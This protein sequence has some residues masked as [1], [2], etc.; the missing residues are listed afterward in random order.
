MVLHT[1]ASEDFTRL[2]NRKSIITDNNNSL[3]YQK[4]LGLGVMAHICNPSE[5]GGRDW[6]NCSSRPA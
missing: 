3:S 2:I 6:E 4:K 5:S 1:E